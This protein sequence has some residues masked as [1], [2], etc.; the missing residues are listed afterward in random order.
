MPDCDHF[1]MKPSLACYNRSM[2]IL[3]KTWFIL[4]SI[5]S[6]CLAG[7]SPFSSILF[8][9]ET[10]DIS[11]GSSSGDGCRDHQGERNPASL[12]DVTAE[13][14]CV[15]EAD[16]PSLVSEIRGGKALTKSRTWRTPPYSDQTEALGYSESA[17]AVPVGMESVVNFWIDIYTKYTTDQGVIHDTEDLGI[18]YETVDFSDIM[19]DVSLNRFQKATQ[20][21]KRVDSLKKKFQAMLLKLQSQEND[22]N[23]SDE[24]KRI[25]NAFVKNENKNKFKEAAENSRVR[26]QLGQKDKIESAI[27]YSGRYL[28]DMEEIFKESGL[29]VELTRIAFVESSFNVLARSKAGASG[30]WQI[31]PYVAKRK[32]TPALDWRNH[33]LEATRIAAKMLK[34]NYGMLESWPLAVTGYNHG[35]TGVKNLTLKF[36]TREISE[37]VANVR[38][39]TFG[40]ASRNFYACFLAILQVERDTSK[41]YPSA[42]WSEKLDMAE[43]TLP[44]AVS[45]KEVLTWFD[46]H[47][48]RAQVFN[49][50]ITSLVRTGKAKIPARSKLWVPREKLE[51][52]QSSFGKGKKARPV[53][54]REEKATPKSHP[55]L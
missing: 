46:G 32:V 18:I 51:E 53:A 41:Y 26:F 47:D 54:T 52:V 12:T 28:E 4:L 40:F 27:F 8:E 38:S 7:P 13:R 3:S 14:M 25:W 31:M 5:G 34:A 20:R 55:E 9:G 16:I 10:G 45:Y 2:R 6:F 23:L 43:L 33:P 48:E 1:L 44:K 22:E 42:V 36:K 11:S 19:T 17:F 39:K 29:P 21:E 49:P 15:L 30:V 50:H 35:P 24:E 37:L